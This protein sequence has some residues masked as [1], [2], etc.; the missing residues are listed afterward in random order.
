MPR[1]VTLPLVVF[2]LFSLCIYWQGGGGGNEGRRRRLL[3]GAGGEPG[4]FQHRHYHDHNH[5]MSPCTHRKRSFRMEG[6]L[7]GNLVGLRVAP[8]AIPHIWAPASFMESWR[9]DM[10]ATGVS[11]FKE[12]EFPVQMMYALKKPAVYID[13]GANQGLTSLP[14]AAMAANHTIYGF[15]PVPE[16]VDLLCMSKNLGDWQYDR[17]HFIEAAVSDTTEMLTLFVPPVRPDNTAFNKDAAVKNVGGE[18]SAIKVHSVML[19]QFIKEENITD[20]ALLKIDVQ[21]HELHVLKGAEHALRS[22]IIKAVHAENDVPITISSGIQ[23]GEIWQFMQSVGFEPF[24][25]EWASITVDESTN[26]I[27]RNP[28]AK[29]VTEWDFTIGKAGM[30]CTYDIIWLPIVNSTT[31]ETKT[32]P[33]FVNI[34]NRL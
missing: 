10:L 7:A 5:F 6:N 8:N 4:S 19:D 33:N 17:L 23:P 2:L 25:E 26:H 1:A 24:N 29:V 18:A 11:R 3:Q 22:K 13:V 21:G 32:E 15:E 30:G 27:V 16:M 28:K 14:V 34:I 20:V 9:K 12:E 31:T